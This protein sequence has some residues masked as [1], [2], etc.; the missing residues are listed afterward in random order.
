ML[1]FVNLLESEKR[2][3]I[4]M[5]FT[6]FTIISSIIIVIDI[7]DFF[8]KFLL[9]LRHLFMFISLFFR[10]LC[11][12]SAEEI[13]F[14]LMGIV[15]DRQLVYTRQI[16]ELTKQKNTLIESVSIK[17]FILLNHQTHQTVWK[18]FIMHTVSELLTQEIC[19]SIVLLLFK[20]LKL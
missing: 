16:D 9:N 1:F 15:S 3:L 5:S 14:N 11:R 6:I 20:N 12:Y 13:H 7:S 2:G 19:K 8:S 17:L 10:F 18:I 4:N